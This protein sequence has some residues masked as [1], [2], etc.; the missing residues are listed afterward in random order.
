ME[1]TAEQTI[2]ERNFPRR[3]EEM[4]RPLIRTGR[5]D[6]F[7]EKWGRFLPKQ[8]FNVDQTPMPFVIDTKRPYEQIEYK[9]TK[10]IW[11]AQ[12][13]AGLEKRQCTVQVCTRAEGIQ[14]RIVIIFRGGGKIVREDE[15]FAWH[16]DVD[17]Y[18]QKNAWADT[19]FS[20]KWAQETLAKSVANLERFV[21]FLDNLTAQETDAFK[22]EVSDLKNA[23]DLW[24]VVDA[25][26]AHMLKVLVGQ[27]HRSWLDEGENAEHWYGHGQP[28]PAGER[29]ILITHWVGEAWNILSGPDYDHLRQRCW[30]KTGCLMTADGSE[31]VKI[32]LEGLPDYLAP[33]P[34]DYLP[35]AETTPI[36]NE[37]PGANNT[38]AEEEVLEEF[39][40]EEPKNKGEEFEDH[41]DDRIDFAPHCGRK[42]RALYG[43][44]WYTGTIQY[45][46]ENLLK[47]RVTF[48]DGPED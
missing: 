33:P 42:L 46:N 38:T 36:P 8:R 41:E 22:K 23:T 10:K 18:W 45:F 28:F 17:V 5:D 26:L 37:P 44:G 35:V 24:Q 6:S 43:N 21:L 4:A 32:S 1:L 13:G 25:I 30:E 3:L 15:K 11:I 29:R 31:D 20:I 12:P 40:E 19:E 2:F 7:E 27:K 47:Y 48:V 34:A 9:H 14:P 39:D 16:P